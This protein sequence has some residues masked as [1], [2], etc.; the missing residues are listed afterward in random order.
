MINLIKRVHRQALIFLIVASAVT[1]GVAAMSGISDWR[2][3]PHSVL[4]GG[5]LGLANFKGLAW[6]LK[7]FAVLQR[8]SGKLIFWSMVR[9]F[10]LAAILVALA[11]M[12]LINFIGIL[13]GLTVVFALI[14]KEGW[15]QFRQS[16]GTKA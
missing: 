1:T 12:H 6:G 5:L 4:I 2:K 9:F 11:L 3:M 15:R 10:I 16:A 13:I 14:L 7:D 8:P